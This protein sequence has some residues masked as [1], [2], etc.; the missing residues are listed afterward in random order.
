[1]LRVSMTSRR[2][3]AWGMVAFGCAVAACSS[4]SAPT[5]INPPS[6]LAA[7]GGFDPNAIVPLASFVDTKALDAAAVQTLL[8]ATPYGGASF[9]ATYTSN[10]VRANDAIARVASLYTLD[11]LVFLTRAEMDQGLLALTAYPTATP[12]R[13][14]Y[15]FGCGCAATGS[16]DPTLAGFDKQIDC[17]G[18]ALRS[19]LDAVTATGA[20]AGHWGPTIT[21]VTLDGV[22]VTPIDASTAALYQYTPIVA[23]GKAG[24]NWLFWNVWQ[25]LA[26]AAGYA[27]ATGTPQT[28]TTGAGWV[29]DACTNTTSCTVPNATCV[30]NYPGGLCTTA[31]TGSC[32][33]DATHG[34]SFCAAFPGQGGYCLPVC[35]PGASVCRSG[36]KCASAAQQG[37]AKT[38]ADVCLPQ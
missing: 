35:N 29:G 31:C 32:P 34:A 15:V 28:P 11:P 2:G 9:L 27:G 36:Y 7:A 5:P 20:T 1:M 24:G 16:C 3:K 33:T 21:G 10:G 23:V 30:T 6:D 37:D 22:S 18:R 38:T 8:E 17:L 13:V 19:S 26:Q 25:K 14:E 12:A 4:S